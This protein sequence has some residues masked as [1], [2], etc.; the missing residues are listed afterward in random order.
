MW[1]SCLARSPCDES[2]TLRCSDR[3]KVASSGR[4]RTLR[5]A[6]PRGPAGGAHG[7]AV[8][9]PGALWSARH[10]RPPL[11]SFVGP[12]GTP[13]GQ[14]VTKELMSDVQSGREMA[15]MAGL[16][17]AGAAGA[18]GVG[19]PGRVAGQVRWFRIEPMGS[20]PSAPGNLLSVANRGFIS[21]FKA[22]NLL[23]KDSQGSSKCFVPPE[24]RAQGCVGTETPGRRSH[25]EP[26]W[27]EAGSKV[28]LKG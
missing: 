8:F 20:S 28:T 7:H 18:A 23:G 16:A 6:P 14:A 5:P 27:G 15:R 1:R 24:K 9:P 4:L 11:P 26:G 17:A 2:A 22:S 21:A 19:W 13:Q 10:P 12:G 3:H 25:Y